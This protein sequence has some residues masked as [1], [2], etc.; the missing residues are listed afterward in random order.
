MGLFED[1]SLQVDMTE[2]PP[3]ESDL[4][5][6]A[7]LDPLLSLSGKDVRKAL[8]SIY[9][10][11]IL[12]E[13]HCLF[14][15]HC[16]AQRGM[17]DERLQ[18]AR[19]TTNQSAEPIQKAM[20]ERFFV[21]F[22]SK[23]IELIED[24][25]N[26]KSRSYDAQVDCEL[27]KLFDT[28]V[29]GSSL[30]DEF[31][32]I[33]A[34]SHTPSVTPQHAGVSRGAFKKYM[35]GFSTRMTDRVLK[36]LRGVHPA[37]YAVLCESDEKKLKL[38]VPEFRAAAAKNLLSAMILDPKSKPLSDNFRRVAMVKDE[39]KNGSE[40]ALF[41]VPEVSK[42]TPERRILAARIFA[43][44]PPIFCVALK[45]TMHPEVVD[46]L[47]KHRKIFLKALTFCSDL[48]LLS[49]VMCDVEGEDVNFVRQFWTKFRDDILPMTIEQFLQDNAL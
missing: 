5:I 22:F 28:L 37:A 3:E 2:L 30:K 6:A 17:F 24:Y 31:M 49:A 33:L 20:I 12:V 34:A 9:I 15:L 27:G 19:S 43:E 1:L 42:F 16:A 4:K 47:G 25:K 32:S 38:S 7:A 11:F 14:A 13:V 46:I 45:K 48:S 44:I 29:P 21:E 23:L 35:E 39:L 8:H 10:A 26:M 41:S 18:K 36:V 40:I